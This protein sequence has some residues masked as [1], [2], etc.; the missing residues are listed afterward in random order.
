MCRKSSRFSLIFVILN[1]MKNPNVAVEDIVAKTKW[2]A[3]LVFRAL[4][5]HA[6]ERK[7]AF[8]KK[9]KQFKFEVMDL[10]KEHFCIRRKG[11]LFDSTLQIDMHSYLHRDGVYGIHFADPRGYD[12]KFMDKDSD[13]IVKYQTELLGRI[14]W[15][16]DAYEKKA[17]EQ[18]V[19]ADLG[20]WSWE[21]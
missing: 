21:R 10:R 4:V 5:S 13:T 14:D 2:S 17:I 11:S 19:Y 1:G 16:F 8:E 15:Y 6:M 7:A 12:I 20:K 3:T 9:Y 18:T